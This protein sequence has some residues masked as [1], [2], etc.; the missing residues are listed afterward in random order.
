MPGIEHQVVLGSSIAPI[1]LSRMGSTTLIRTTGQIL[2]KEPPKSGPI[3]DAPPR[4]TSIPL[5]VD[6]LEYAPTTGCERCV[7]RLCIFSVNP[8]DSFNQPF[9]KPSLIC[10]TIHT[11]RQG[12]SVYLRER[13]HCTGWSRRSLS[14]C[15]GHRRRLYS[16]LFFALMVV[17]NVD[18][19]VNSQSYQIPDYTAYDQVLTAFKRLVP[20]PTRECAFWSILDL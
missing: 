1:V 4:P 13:L 10:T 12:Q 2:A 6:S 20:V 11:G 7:S 19:A 15:G 14:C 5:P 9:E 18:P 17:I 8:S 16:Q 3:P